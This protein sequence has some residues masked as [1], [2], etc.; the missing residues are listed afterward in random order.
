[1]H[2]NIA[3]KQAQAD[4]AQTDSMMQAVMHNYN[5]QRQGGERQERAAG[6]SRRA[7]DAYAYQNEARLAQ[8]AL[9]RAVRQDKVYTQEAKGK[10]LSHHL[11]HSLQ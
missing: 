2:Q 10:P 4:L 7:A 11:R 9:R 6:H 3:L 5:Y 8:G 1:M